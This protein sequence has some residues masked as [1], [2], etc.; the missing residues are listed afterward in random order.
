ME[1][2]TFPVAPDMGKG[3]DLRLSRRQQLFHREFRRGVQIHRPRGAV[4][5]DS[6]GDKTVQMRLVSGRDGQGRGIHLRKA[7]PG[8]PHPQGR[9]NPVAR[10]QNRAAVGVALGVPPGSCGIHLEFPVGMR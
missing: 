5:A 2:P 8:Q 1:R 3:V 9:L 7:S 10:Q 4:R 6:L